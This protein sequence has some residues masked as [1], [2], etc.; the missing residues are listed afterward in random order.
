MWHPPSPP[1]D[2][3]GALL[4]SPVSS[5]HRPPVGGK[6]TLGQGAL[7]RGVHAL[8]GMPRQRHP[9]LGA[10]PWGVQQRGPARML[11]STR[12]ALGRI[13]LANHHVPQLVC[14]TCLLGRQKSSG[15]FRLKRTPRTLQ[16]VDQ[17]Y[18]PVCCALSGAA[19]RAAP[20]A[21]GRVCGILPRE[22]PAGSGRLRTRLPG[23]TLPGAAR[24][25]SVARWMAL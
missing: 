18:P 5:P 8:A 11:W 9:H 14:P 6:L 2:V 17:Q 10:L 24:C 13:P 22:A 1:V 4:A 16:E 15:N 25:P 23:H 7:S 12:P 3:V 21:G 19:A 20:W